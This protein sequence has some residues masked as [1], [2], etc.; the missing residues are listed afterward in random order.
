MS[1]VTKEEQ[2]ANA[3]VYDVLV[4]GGGAAGFFGAISVA[5]HY[6]GY[7]KIAILERGNQ[8]LSKVKISGGGRCNVT[9]DCLEPKALIK[10]YPRG[11]KSL[12][13]PFH[14]FGPS[15]TIE[16]FTQRG[17]GLK[18]E[19]DGR[20]FPET[21]SSQTIIDCLTDEAETSGIE[22]YKKFGVKSV[23]IKEDTIELGLASGECLMTRFLLIATGGTRLAAGTALFISLEHNLMPAVPSLFT[24]TI[25]DD[26]I[27]GLSGL[28]VS[29]VEIHILNTAFKAQGPLL[30]THWGISGPG[31][32]K[33]SSMAAR[34]LAEKD[35]TF[36]ISV[37]WC[38]SIE[39]E[40]L[41]LLKRKEWGKRQVSTRSPLASIPKRLW[42]R[43]CENA[44]ISQDV[45]WSQLSKNA[46]E[47][48]KYQIRKTEFQ[49]TGKSLNK[50]EFVT[51]GGVSLKEI[52]LKTMESK[53]H[54]NIHYAGEVI[55]VDGIT[56]G[57]NF[58]N[59]WTTGYLAGRA[60]AEK[61]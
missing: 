21:N 39:L 61:L 13:G 30:I 52:D 24:F 6:D 47:S 40:K 26:L 35:Y 27:N 56:G 17:V 19:D 34:E 28:S 38:P 51:C 32:L 1:L 60:I 23:S 37:N 10:H 45:T 57:F 49:V 50:E 46:E 12:I 16:W 31:V 15:D 9:H 33:L 29:H 8:V 22:V 44:D 58:Q 5:E 11:M 4:I 18:V 7:V 20:M 43:F 55:D 36:K 54:P 42:L 41:F 2:L 59:A 14:H 25:E 3:E 48:V 53:Q